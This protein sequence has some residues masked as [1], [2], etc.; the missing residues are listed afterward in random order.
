[1][2]IYSKEVMES[3]RK[4]GYYNILKIEN[5]GYCGIMNF[6]FT[7]ALVVGINPDGTYDHRYCYPK[8]ESGATPWPYLAL[9]LWSSPSNPPSR[10]EHPEDPYWIKRKGEGPCSNPLKYKK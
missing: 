10:D 6:I 1:M 2:E 3:L 8:V 7:T 9:L 5:K 4:E